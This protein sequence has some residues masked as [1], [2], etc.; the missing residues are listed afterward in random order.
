MAP[1]FNRGLA[2]QYRFADM[3]GMHKMR[4]SPI[5]AYRNKATAV[6]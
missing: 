3:K 6:H 1:K 5:S 4:L 2:P